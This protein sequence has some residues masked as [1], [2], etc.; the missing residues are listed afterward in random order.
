ML[1]KTLLRLSL[2]AYAAAVFALPLPALAASDA[3]D[4]ER[5]EIRQGGEI[6]LQNFT[7]SRPRLRPEVMAAAGY[8]LFSTASRGLF[9]R[10][11]EG[12]STRGTGIAV[13]RRDGSE[14]FMRMSQPA[15]A[16]KAPATDR[17][18]LIVFSTRQAFEA[19]AAR[20]WKAEAGAE[21]LPDAK[22]YALT[23]T[24]VE[25]APSLAGLAFWKDRALN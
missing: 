15:P 10:G 5:A 3:D 24:G 25:V 2:A 18:I 12:V 9:N 4:G 14:T 17:Q 8:A 23:R 11:T 13:D 1:P 20:G 22:V 7:D 19:F 16:E 21:A 6:L